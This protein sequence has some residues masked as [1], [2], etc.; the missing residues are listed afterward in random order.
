MTALRATISY[1]YNCLVDGIKN[2]WKWRKTIY[3]DRDWDYW[4]IYEILKTK[5]RFQAEYM[6]NHGVTE[7]STEVAKQLLGCAEMIDK[8]QNEYY[9][10]EAIQG[11]GNKQ[12]SNEM[13]DEGTKKHE[14]VKTKLYKTIQ[15]NIETWW[16]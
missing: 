12:W 8:I 6:L 9:I 14:E 7:K 16:D 1:K 5:L 3:R 11:L 15:D 2:L 13:W 10:D 4:Y